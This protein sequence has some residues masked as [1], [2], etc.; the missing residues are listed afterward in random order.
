MLSRFA[1]GQKFWPK[2]CQSN[3]ADEEEPFVL[4]ANVPEEK[5]LCYRY[6]VKLGT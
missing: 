1:N 2:L 5:L 3:K 4:V 6:A